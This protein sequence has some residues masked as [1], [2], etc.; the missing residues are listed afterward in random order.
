M[1][2]IANVDVCY[3]EDA[4]EISSDKGETI[5]LVKEDVLELLRRCHLCDTRRLVCNVE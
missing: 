5:G 1:T 3:D 2:Y 4:C